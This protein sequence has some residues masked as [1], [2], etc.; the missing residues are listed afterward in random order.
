MTGRVEQATIG[1]VGRRFKSVNIYIKGGQCCGSG[2]VAQ[3]RTAT[4]ALEIVR[5]VARKLIESQM[6]RSHHIE[7]SSI[8]DSFN[9]PRVH[10]HTESGGQL[11]MNFPAMTGSRLIRA[12]KKSGFS[13]IRKKE[14]ITSF[15]IKTG[16][17]PSFLCTGGS[18]GRGLLAQILRDCDIT[19]EDLQ[20]QF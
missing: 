17:A 14:T 3:G 20:K 8:S 2:L 6:K 7:L 4:E 13:V 15:N 9:Y 1:R 5:D 16:D 12:L 18:I 11:M 19:K 10:W